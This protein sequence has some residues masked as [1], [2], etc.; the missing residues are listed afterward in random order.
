MIMKI[1]DNFVNKVGTDKILHFLV[2]SLITSI[3]TFVII[4]QDAIVSPVA[5][6]VPLAGAGLTALLA[7]A[8]EMLDDQFSKKDLIASILGAIPIIIAV[9]IGVLFNVLSN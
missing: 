8:K 9:A 1:V 6:A 3:L 5:I 2:G 4:I 7:W